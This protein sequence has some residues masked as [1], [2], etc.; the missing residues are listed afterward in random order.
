MK[1]WLVF[2]LSGQVGA[3]LRAALVAGEAELVAVSRQPP[4]D[5]PG[6]RW[7]R[8]QLGPELAVG[9]GFDAVISLGPLDRFS[10]WFERSGLAPARV[11][12]LGSTSVHSKSASPDPAERELAARL[13]QAE[14]RLAAACADRRSAC[15]LLRPTL[16]Y[17]GG[18]R[19]LSRIAGLARR[20]RWLPLPSDAT[21]RRQPV[22]AGDL[23]AA[24]LACLRSPAA[25]VG[26]YDLPGGE[27]LAYDEMLRRVLAVAAPR[28]RILR[29]PA[30]L[31]RAGV[32]LLRPLGLGGAGEGLL[33]RF[34]RDLVF[35]AGPA[36]RD[37]GYAPRPFQPRADMF[38]S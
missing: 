16:I 11:V 15:A 31:F 34:N 6:L 2:G 32:R 9:D 14:A 10:C 26:S 8:G 37:L 33:S 12:A 23:A 30:P 5:A 24:V 35:D 21:G 22:H 7:I 19:S 27:T 20:W 29:L 1:R 18:E 28:A 4:D 36:R 17:G 13:A 3:A 25:I 38:R